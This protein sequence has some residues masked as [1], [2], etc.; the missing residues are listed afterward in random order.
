[1]LQKKLSSN[2]S[3]SMIQIFFLSGIFKETGNSD[4]PERK[5]ETIQ[6]DKQLRN[7]Y[8]Y[9]SDSKLERSEKVLKRS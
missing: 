5:H 7:H 1:M 4:C 6:I 3:A 2:R 9:C 8:K